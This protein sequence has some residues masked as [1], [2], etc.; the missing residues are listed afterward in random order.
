MPLEGDGHLRLTACDAVTYCQEACYVFYMV[1]QRRPIG[2]REPL[3][4]TD[5]P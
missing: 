5:L 1:G 2:R 3:T 4:L